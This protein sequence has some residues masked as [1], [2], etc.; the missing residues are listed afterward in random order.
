MATCD[1]AD[2]IRVTA[3]MSYNTGADDIQNVY[4][5]KLAQAGG[6]VDDAVVHAGIASA[7]DTAYAYIQA[8]LP[9]TTTF[10]TIQTWN[11]TQDR[12]MLEAV[13]PTMNHGT[14][15]GEAMPA[16]CA[17]LCLFNTASPRSQ[18]RKYLPFMRESDM[19]A[20]VLS[21]STLTAIALWIATILTGATYSGGSATA[22]NW[23]A[24][25][26][27]FAQWLVGTAEAIVRTQRRRVMGVGA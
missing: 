6:A 26:Y 24:V 22:G 4:F 20:G 27:R 15:T 5:F 11:V 12:P 25:K 19:S 18:G 10:D 17:P 8:R 14:G 16:Q 2:I 7:L 13:W 21:S 1:S 23:N 9:T 3:K